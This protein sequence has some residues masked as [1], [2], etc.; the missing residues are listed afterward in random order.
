MYYNFITFIIIMQP[1]YNVDL[2]SQFEKLLI[3]NT[4]L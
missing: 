4:A 3:P 2:V 1:T